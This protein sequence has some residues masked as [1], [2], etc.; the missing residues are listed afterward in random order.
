MLYSYFV[1]YS[2]MFMNYLVCDRCYVTRSQVAMW[3]FYLSLSSGEFTSSSSPICGSWYLPIFLF[4]DG[5][6][7]D[8]DG[9]LN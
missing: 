6:Q 5:S 8:E 3:L 7:T 2:L 1:E 4:R 9:F